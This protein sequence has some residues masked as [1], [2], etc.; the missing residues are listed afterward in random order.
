MQNQKMMDGAKLLFFSLIFMVVAGLSQFASTNAAPSQQGTIPT[1]P[2]VRLI[3]PIQAQ[4]SNTQIWTVA[5]VQVQTADARV[6]ERVGPAIVGAWVSVDGDA[7]GAGGILASRIKVMPAQRFV[8]LAGIYWLNGEI[9]DNTTAD[10][11][12]VA[13]KLNTA[14]QLKGAPTAGRPCSGQA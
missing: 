4:D 12:G 10:V 14:T 11:G 6:L 2:H 9:T 5:G 7:D 8:K 13:I 1:N 3:G